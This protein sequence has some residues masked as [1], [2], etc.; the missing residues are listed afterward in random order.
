M[1][2]LKNAVQT[3]NVPHIT[4]LK[5]FSKLIGKLNALLS[6]PPDSLK[7]SSTMGGAYRRSSKYTHLSYA[8]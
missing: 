1:I 5:C 7:H 2:Y 6:N 3:S 8:M 4:S